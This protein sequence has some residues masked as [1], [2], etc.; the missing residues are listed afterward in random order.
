MV[1]QASH[2]EFLERINGLGGAGRFTLT[3]RQLE[4]TGSRFIAPSHG[5]NLFFVR[6]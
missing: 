1:T 3:G 4:K 5:I 6:K 2:E